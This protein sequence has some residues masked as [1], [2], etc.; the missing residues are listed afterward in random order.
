MEKLIK[1]K[2]QI[3]ELIDENRKSLQASEAI[4]E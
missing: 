4:F 1:D 2:Q 3:D